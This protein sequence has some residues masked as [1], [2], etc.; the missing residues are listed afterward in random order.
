MSSTAANPSP[1]Q[2]LLRTLV[3]HIASQENTP[4][5]ITQLLGQ[6][7]EENHK[8]TGKALHKLVSRQQEARRG[9]AKTR[10]DRAAYDNAWGA[11]LGHLAQLLEQQMKD[12]TAAIQAFDQAE[13]TWRTQLDE[14]TVEL[15]RHTATQPESSGQE[16]IDVDAEMEKQEQMVADAAQEEVRAALK[17]E[18]QRE[19]TEAKAKEMLEAIK[20]TQ[21]GLEASGREGSRT[22]RRS[23]SKEARK[24]ETAPDKSKPA[25]PTPPG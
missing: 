22:P 1:E 13:E 4:A 11:Y 16:T 6:Y 3:A 8:A 2:A 19:D 17:R 7:Q 10:T 15:S 12:R 24:D 21:R 23:A 14:T 25:G 9:L 5:E 20:Q 18:K